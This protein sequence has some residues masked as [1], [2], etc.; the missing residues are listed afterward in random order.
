IAAS[1]T[2]YSIGTPA[3][4]AMVIRPRDAFAQ[5]VATHFSPAEQ[6]DSAR[7]GPLAAPFG[8]G[9]PNLLRAALKLGAGPLAGLIAGGG[10]DAAS[11]PV[12]AIEDGH[13]VLRYRQLSGGTGTPGIDYTAGGLRYVVEMCEDL[14][15]GE[16]AWQSGASVV[17]P[18]GAPQV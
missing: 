3:S 8:D 13:L 5:W 12:A 18:V 11:L 9:V 10:A 15:A 1:A 14:S 7:S 17:E 4:A 16:A 6:A 2:S